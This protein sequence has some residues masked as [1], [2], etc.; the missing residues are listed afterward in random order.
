MFGN[1]NIK[2]GD[3]ILNDF[4]NTIGMIQLVLMCEIVNSLK[5]DVE[6]FV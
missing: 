1:R 5:L 4:D 3:F 6:I 2:K